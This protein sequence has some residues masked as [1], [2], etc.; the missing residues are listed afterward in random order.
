MALRRVLAFVDRPRERF[1]EAAAFWTAVTGTRLSPRRGDDGEFA[2]LL[3]ESGD[4]CVKLQAVGG[5]GG[6]HLDLEVDDV[7]AAV[8]GA[9][10]LGA[11]VAADHGDWAVLRSPE[12]RAFCLVPSERAPEERAPEERVSWEGAARRPPVFGGTRLDQVCLDIAPGAYE[13]EVA[14]WAAL[15][16]WPPRR[17]SLPE[18]TVLAMPGMPV[19]VLLQRLGEG[20]GRSAHIDLACADAEAARLLHERHGA[21]FVAR[22]RRWIVMR[23][24]AG[25]VYCLTERDPETGALLP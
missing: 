13:E 10:A 9:V 25:G 12:G 16:G 21:V 23:D 8:A 22:G 5:G 4:A 7:R 24:P 17:G 3:P 6:A 11:D 19:R 15:I 2:T 14:F 18:F 1:E 20:P